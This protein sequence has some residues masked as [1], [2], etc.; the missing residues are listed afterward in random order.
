MAFKLS[1]EE[2]TQLSSLSGQLHQQQDEI[3]G[4]LQKVNEEIKELIERELT[5]LIGTYNDLIGAALTLLEDVASNLR[6][7]FDDK[8]EGW[9][10]GERGQAIDS[11]IQE[12]ENVSISA[13]DVPEPEDITLE[14]EDAGDT[15]AGLPDEPSL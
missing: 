5:P 4:A 15:L 2:A 13:L 6:G 12:F 10:A 9:Q 3:E 1:K 8:S 7:E 14:L 11:W